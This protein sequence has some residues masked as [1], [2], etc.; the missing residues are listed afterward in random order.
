MDTIPNPCNEV[1]EIMLEINEEKKFVSDYGYFTGDGREYV[2]TRPDTPKPWVNIICP[3]K[4][5]IALSQAGS[6]YSWYIHA[7]LNR[8]TRWEQDLI[9]DEW[10]KYFYL[11]DNQSGE[12]WSA[13]WK[14]VGRKPDFYE[15]RHGIGYSII[16]S[17]NLGILTELTFFVPKDDSLE[18]CLLKIKN[19]TDTVRQLS[20]FTYLEWCLG[21]APDSHRE[22]HKTFIETDFKEGTI[23]AR[24]RLWT[25]KN[26]KGQHWNID[27]PYLAF[28]SVNYPV[29]DYS[30]DKEA[31]LGQYGDLVSPQAVVAGKY[32]SATTK[33]WDDGIG[34]L[35]LNISLNPEEEKTFVFTLGLAE[36]DKTARRT[37][38]KYKKLETAENALREVKDFWNKYLARN[39]IQTPN[40]AFNFMNNIWLKYQTI[41]GRIW[42]RTGYYQVGGAYG[43]RDQLQD[44]Q[45]FLPLKPELTRKQILRHCQHQFKDG[46]VYHWW[47]PLIEEG[48]VTRISDDLLWL[49]FIVVNYLKETGDFSIL[50]EKVKFL[51]APADTVYRH[52]ELAIERVFKRFSKR[53][54]PL[55]GEGDWNDGLSC[56]GWEWKGES[57]WLGHFFYGI[58]KDWV[59]VIGFGAEHRQIAP[60]E[61]QKIKKYSHQAELLK[62]KINRYCWDGNWYY[63]ATLDDGDLIGSKKNKEG[64]IFLNAQ[65]W[66][67]INGIADENRKNLLLKS[68]EKYLYRDFGPVLLYPAYS[69]PDGRIGYLTRYAPGVRENGGLYTHA[70]CWVVQMECLLKH[71]DQAWKLYQSFSPVYR[72]LKPELYSCEPYVTPGNVDGPDSP[73]YG[74]GGW[75]WYT[76]SAGW[77][78]RV[79]MEWI[80]GVRPTWQGLMVDP[81]LPADW[82]NFKMKR[83]FR[84]AEYEIEVTKKENSSLRIKKISV[85]GKDIDGNILPVFKDKKVHK[86]AVRM[87]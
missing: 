6:G 66:A 7:G 24:K 10:G 75:T 70:G 33:R 20:L 27:W 23:F 22:F 37:S 4:Y 84:G 32:L 15:C 41:S 63:R 83:I 11:R 49:P 46:T 56:V 85:D 13:A 8:L 57:V 44:S 21:A 30:G 79:G 38:D 67:V 52:C 73:Y 55:I 80:L 60:K 25:V 86:V 18:V 19:T 43:F 87:E 74:R 68:L 72:G 39:W 9:K 28:H 65:T 34:S 81:C 5:G 59:E 82:L 47:H 16:R 50:R 26:A 14:P 77:L 48:A 53:G 61:K 17:R 54:L 40:E 35:L 69:R 31:F 71:N 58:L 45:I 64:K 51:D 3:G 2:I 78:F 1:V 62:K 36:N 29:A 12:I 76:G 42:G